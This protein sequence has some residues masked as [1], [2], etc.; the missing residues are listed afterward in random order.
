MRDSVSERKREREEKRGALPSWKLKLSKKRSGGPS[1]RS[2]YASFQDI[3]WRPSLPQALSPPRRAGLVHWLLSHL[4]CNYDTLRFA[5]VLKDKSLDSAT[6]YYSL[7]TWNLDLP[8]PH[9]SLPAFFICKNTNLALQLREWFELIDKSWHVTILL[10]YQVWFLIIS[11][12]YA[13][14]SNFKNVRGLCAENTE[15]FFLSKAILV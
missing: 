3:F 4:S 6:N 13:P 7:S 10:N 9:L 14:R 2:W 12:Y 1:S 15:Y 8:S 11:Q 5:V